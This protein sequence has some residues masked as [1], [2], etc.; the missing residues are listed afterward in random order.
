MS[1]AHTEYSTWQLKAVN[2]YVAI[3]E[4]RQHDDQIID[5]SSQLR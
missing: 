2:R 1:T 3:S 4:A 5:L